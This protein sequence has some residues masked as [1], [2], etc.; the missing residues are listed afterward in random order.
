MGWP[1]LVSTVQDAIDTLEPGERAGAIVFTANYGEAGAVELLAHDPPPVYSGH[2]GYGDWG[3]PP[4]ASTST[5]L[6]GHW[7]VETMRWAFGAC[8]LSG[9][10]DNQRRTGQRGAGRRRVGLSGPHATMG[11]ALAAAPTPQLSD[12]HL[13]RD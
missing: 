6:V 5:I 9:R 10:V 13:G 4:E 3:P 11:R 2:N 1:E 12:H 7:D 8:E